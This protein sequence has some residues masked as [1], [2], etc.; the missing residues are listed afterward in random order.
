MQKF[1]LAFVFM[2]ISVSTTV[3]AEE[4]SSLT[5]R[6]KE[7]RQRSI[8]YEEEEESGDGLIPQRLALRLSEH[9]A[10]NIGRDIAYNLG[11]IFRH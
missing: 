2:S 9:R 1:M 4:L 8:P 7:L 3:R 10:P 5:Q 11:L 6:V